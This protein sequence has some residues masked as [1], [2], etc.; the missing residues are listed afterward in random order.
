[1]NDK[2]SQTGMNRRSFL[3]NTAAVSASL[4]FSPYIFTQAANAA[5]SGDVINVALIGAGAEG[6]KV[7]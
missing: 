3:Q 1:M 6:Q 2:Q 5:S 7:D 4:A